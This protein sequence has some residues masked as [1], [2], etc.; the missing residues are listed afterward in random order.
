MHQDSHMGAHRQRVVITGIAV[1]T[2]LG[3]TSDAYFDSLMAGKSAITRWKF[4]DTSHI[5]SKVGADLSDYD[6][7][8]KL[9]ALSPK[10]DLALFKRLRKLVSRAPFSTRLSLLCAADAYLDAGLSSALDPDRIGVVVAGH[11]LHYQFDHVTTIQFLEEPDFIDPMLSLT[12]LDTDQAASISE[13]LGTMG[14]LYTVGGACASGNIALR[15]AMDEIRYHDMDV[16]LVVGPVFDFS[17][18]GLHSLAMMGAITA[19]HFRDEPTRASRP[20]DTAREG[21]VPAHGAGVLVVEALD[22]ALR[23]N[24]HI[25]AELLAVA[26]TSD[27]SHLPTPALGGQVRAMNRVL[28]EACVA[29]EDVTYINAHA[30]STPLGDICEVQAIKQVF[31]QHTARLKINATKSMIG[32]CCWSAPIVE[33]IAAILQMNRSRLHPSINIDQLD[34]EIDLDVCAQGPVDWDIPLLMKNAFGFGGINCVSL[35]KRF[36]A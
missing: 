8:A 16:M 26:M 14:S 32:H 25:Y 29:P 24:A 19:Q 3:D 1:N 30:T 17:V 4:A 27:A 33:S 9:T 20:F 36:E 13:A 28:K 2:P 10:L 7:N 31:G 5:Y 11:N 15:H 23:R 6:T 12:G 18:K 22:H 34:P 35:F 21:F